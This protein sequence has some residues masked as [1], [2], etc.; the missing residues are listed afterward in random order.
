MGTGIGLSAISALFQVLSYCVN[1]LLA[2]VLGPGAFADYALLATDFSLFGAIAEFGTGA[3]ILSF[4]AGR[5]DEPAIAHSIYR[6]K[7]LLAFAAT[8]LMSVLVLLLRAPSGMAVP[9]LV[10]ATGYLVSPG[11]VEW[12]FLGTKDWTRLVRFKLIHA[13]TYVFAVALLLVSGFDS[14][15][16]VCLAV[17]LAPL[18]AFLY[19][20][21]AIP[22]NSGRLRRSQIRLLKLVLKAAVPYA[23]SGLASFAYLPAIL[24]AANACLEDGG[25]RAAFTASY[26]VVFVLQAFAVQFLTSEQLFSKRGGGS[27]PRSRLK[28]CLLYAAAA[29]FALSPLALFG[30]WVPRVL[31]FGLDWTPEMGETAD[32]TLRILLS[33]IV[34]QFAR[35]PALA[36]FL[37]DR[38]IGIG[39][40]I[41]A[42]GGLAN[43]VSLLFAGTFRPAWLAP[44][45]LVGDFVSTALMI[46]VHMRLGRGARAS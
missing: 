27:D 26:K 31:F 11:I 32:F 13:G 36:Q 9:G 2:H 40:T 41:V 3:L 38:K 30:Q 35:M 24:Y 1:N 20:R 45:G 33:S 29:A 14:L 4:F 23:L 34:L 21:R 16:P 5:L 22:G 39:A 46:A 37:A 6:L 10:L 18:P 8:A 44:A 28:R 7:T 42:V 15:T 25:E 43:L 12:F 19:A 17:T